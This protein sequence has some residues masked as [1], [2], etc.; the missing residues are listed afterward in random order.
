MSS[1]SRGCC[2]QNLSRAGGEKGLGRQDPLS[3]RR[4]GVGGDRLAR[5]AEQRRRPAGGPRPDS[6][7]GRSGRA[8]GSLPSPRIPKT[9]G[10]QRSADMSSSSGRA[11]R[12]WRQENGVTPAPLPR[13]P[14]LP[15]RPPPPRPLETPLWDGPVRPGP[16]RGVGS[17]PQP[18]ARYLHAAGSAPSGW[19]A[20][21]PDCAPDSGCPE[22]CAGPR[23]AGR[24]ALA[25]AR[26][27]P[28]GPAPARCL[29]ARLGPGGGP[30]PRGHL[31][32]IRP[33][34]AKPPAPGQTSPGCGLRLLPQPLHA[35]P[36]PAAR[37]PAPP[38]PA[39]AP[40][41]PTAPPCTHL[42]VSSPSL[43]GFH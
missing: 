41:G 6:Q 10:A 5:P 40:S 8:G 17:V 38:A 11:R 36:G 32:L 22:L 42:L 14:H 33:D 30:A 1:Q 20:A 31:C 16:C 43:A 15:C 4:L 29:G 37:P 2:G 26:P 21:V 19:A 39:R 18:G 24:P 9:C 35:A 27:P 7:M 3:A 34:G 12:A 13:T 28:P 25:A 23:P